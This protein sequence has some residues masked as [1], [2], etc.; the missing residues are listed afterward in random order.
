MWRASPPLWAC[1]PELRSRPEHSEITEQGGPVDDISRIVEKFNQ[2][3]ARK[4]KD[5]VD[6]VEQQHGQQ[7]EDEPTDP[8]IINTGI[9]YGGQHVSH[10]TIVGDYHPGNKNDQDDE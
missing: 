5:L 2:D 3:V 6:Q 4:V 1:G 9:V 10:V 7:N 8:V